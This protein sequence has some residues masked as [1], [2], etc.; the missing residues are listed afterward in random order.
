MREKKPVNSNMNVHPASNR[1]VIGVALTLLYTL[2]FPYIS[3]VPLLDGAIPHLCLVPI[4]GWA[5][6]FGWLGGLIAGILVPFLNISLMILMKTEIAPSMLQ[7]NTWITYFFSILVGVF[8]G[9]VNTYRKNQ[10]RQLSKQVSQEKRLTYLA[11]HDPLTSL[12][13]RTLLYDRLQHA[14]AIADRHKQSFAVLFIDMDNFKEVNDSCGH[15]TGDQLLMMLAQ[16]LG[17]CLRTSDTVAR[18]GGDEFIILLEGVKNREAI[19]QIGEKVL[20]YIAEPMLIGEVSFTVT[21]SI[22]IS[23]YPEDHQDIEALLSLADSAM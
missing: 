2:L 13:N 15:A 22:G 19:S 4:I 20:A 18:I 5:L 12:P 14:K 1:F 3:Q 11:T 7:M 17:R 21:A 10:V 16:R 9:A 23:T 6:L 8:V